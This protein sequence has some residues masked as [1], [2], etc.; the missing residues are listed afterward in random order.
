LST[1][2]LLLPDLLVEQRDSL[3]RTAERQLVS[4]WYFGSDVLESSSSSTA[5]ELAH[6]GSFSQP[7]EV[8]FSKG[9]L[10]LLEFQ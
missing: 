1:Q 4:F 10:G 5:A 7:L 8:I 2:S 6:L 3:V 9:L